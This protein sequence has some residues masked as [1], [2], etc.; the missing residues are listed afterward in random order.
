MDVDWGECTN[1]QGEDSSCLQT[2]GDLQESAGIVY[3]E[4]GKS[5]DGT[6][7]EVK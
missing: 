1:K 3:G 2:V 7:S 4:D 6:T 5:E